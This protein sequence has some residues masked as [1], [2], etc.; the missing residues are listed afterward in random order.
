MIR[1]RIPVGC[2]CGWRGTRVAGIA[3]DSPYGTCPKCAARL[4]RRD[5]PLAAARR[6]VAKRELMYE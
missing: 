3:D 5:S 2:R 4:Q 6:A 1:P